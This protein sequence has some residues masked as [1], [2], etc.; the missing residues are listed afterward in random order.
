M[1]PGERRVWRR[2]QPEKQLALGFAE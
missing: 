1:E 2:T